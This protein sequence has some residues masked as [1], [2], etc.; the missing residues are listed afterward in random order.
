MDLQDATL[1][2]LAESAGYPAVASIA[3]SASGPLVQAARPG[4]RQPG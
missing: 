3:Q 2:F 1:M 4:P